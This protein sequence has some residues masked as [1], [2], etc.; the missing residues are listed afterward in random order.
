ME[1]CVCGFETR[2]RRREVSEIGRVEGAQEEAEEDD[3][4]RIEIEIKNLLCFKTTP[5]QMQWM[6]VLCKVQV[7]CCC[8]RV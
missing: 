8:R 7:E 1:F 6:R 4:R 5:T 3:E 2:I